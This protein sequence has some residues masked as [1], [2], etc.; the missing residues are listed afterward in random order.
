[1]T[2]IRLPSRLP[3]LE[4][5]RGTIVRLLYLAVALAALINICGSFWFNARD[6]FGNMP[7]AG[8][9]GFRT[10]T[11]VGHPTIAGAAS[12]EAIASGL[13]RG[14]RILSIDGEPLAADATEFTIG[15]RI[16]ADPDGRIA[17]V[18]RSTDGSVRTHRL[19]RAPVGAATVEPVTRLPLWLYIAAGFGGTQLPL[20]LWFAAS[21]LLARRRPRDPEAMLFAFGFLLMSINSGSG[22]W[23]IAFAGVPN[24]LLEKITNIGACMLIAAIAGFPDGRFPTR[25]S[26]LTLAAAMLLTA[27][28]LV[29]RGS[30]ALTILFTLC[31]IGLAASVIARYRSARVG[32]ERQ[33][34]KWAVFGFAAA[35]IIMVPVQ[36]GLVIAMG[37]GEPRVRFLMDRLGISFALLLIPAGLL[38]SL[39]RYRLYDAEAAMSRSAGYAVLTLLLGATFAASAE[40]LEWFF[41]NSLGQQGSA[42]P[43]AIAAALAVVLITPLNQRI[44]DWAERRFQKG[45]LHLR[46]DLPDCVGDMRETSALEP[47]LAEAMERISSAVRASRSAAIVAG[48]VAAVREVPLEEVEAWAAGAR[49]DPAGAQMDCDRSDPLFPMRVPLRV[50]HG[51]AEPV[52]W[53]LLGPRPDGSFYGKDEQEALAEVADPLARALR[54]V[55]LREEREAAQESR[56]GA[57]EARLAEAL[58]ALGPREAGPVA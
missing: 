14:D 37:E 47:L 1:M 58:R 43:G 53:I 27:M 7:T 6:Y 21:L 32:I 5:R 48:R 26:R 22:F 19:T 44:Q 41:E 23:L 28:L 15:D 30:L 9:Y 33:Q 51:A 31:S 40:A 52:G 12:A 39:L 56:L 2:G 34:I 25:L 10:Q 46:R 16:A 20:L 24:F 29:L 3:H 42:V 38:V 8:S 45:L 55:M 49:L 50:R 17:L 18:T 57:I 36:I 35:F 4:G 11:S 54:V 13:R